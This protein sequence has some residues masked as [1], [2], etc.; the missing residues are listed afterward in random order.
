MNYLSKSFFSSLVIS[1]LLFSAV[2]IAQSNKGSIVGT[3]SDPSGAL[4]PNAKVTVT[5]KATGGTREVTSNA[6]GEFSVSNL[7]PGNYSVKVEAS[8]FKSILLSSLTVETN[9]RV[10]IAAVFTEVAGTGTNVVEV[11]ADS[12]PLVESETS[13]RGDLITG[14]EVTDLPIP[15]RNFTL[16][17]GLSPGVT[18][19]SA[20]SVGV[21]GGGGNFVNGGPGASSESTRFRESGGSVISANGARV[22]QNNF[23]LD[24]VDNNESQFGQIAVYPNPDAIAEFKIE[25]SVPSAESGRAAGAIIST[26]FKSGGNE[27][28]GTIFENYQGRFLS[29]GAAQFD[30]NGANSGNNPNYVTHNYGGTVGGPIF[31]PRPGINNKDP[32][33]YDGRNRSF[34]FVS[35]AGQRNGTP[36]FGGGEF[37]FVT[38]PTA[39][40]RAGD[41]SELLTGGNTTY[42]L[43][44]GGQVVAPTGTIFAPDGTPIPGNNL[45]NCA[46]CGA[47]SVYGSNLL[48]AYPLPTEAGFINNYRRNRAERSTVDSYDV[49]IDHRINDSNTIFGRYSRAKNSRIRDNNFPLGTSPNG[50]DLPSGFGAGDEFGNSRGITLGATQIFSPTVVNDMRAGW[51]KVQIGINNPGINGSLGFNPGVDAALGSTNINAC[52]TCEG[53]SLIGIVD[54]SFSQEFVGDGGPFFFLSNNYNFADTVTIARGNS[55]LKFG[56]DLRNRRNTNFDGGR[57]GGT[58]GQYQY[59]T[60]VGGFASGNYNGIGPNDTGSAVANFLLGYQPGFLGRGT[61]G[62]PYTLQSS[63]LAFFVQNDWK[64]SPDLT[65]NLGLRYDIFTA[66]TERFDRQVNFDPASGNLIVAGENAPGG[67]DLAKNDLNNFGPRI[68]FAY[69][70]FMDRKLVVRGGYGLVYTTDVSGVQP[71]TANPGTGAANFQ[72][73]PI[74]NPGGCPPTYPVGRYPFETGIPFAPGSE[75][76][77]APGTIFPAPGGSQIIFNDPDRRDAF[78]HQYNLTLQYEFATNWLA[79]IAYVGSQ[80]RNLLTVTNIGNNND[81]GGPGSREVANISNVIATR[82]NASANYNSMQT[83]LEK[84]FTDGLSILSTY[85][86]AKAISDNP[87]GFCFGGTGPSTCGPD[88]PLRPELDRALSDLDVR[89]RFTFANV[90]DL[91]IGIG[92][93]Y[94]KDIPTGLDYLIGGWQLNNIVTLQSGPVFTVT[95]GGARVNIVGDPTPTQQQAA[96]GRQLNINAFAPPTIPVFANDPNGPKI[97]TLGRNTFRGESQQYWDANI[98]KNFPVRWI[99]EAFNVQVRISVFNVLNHVN[100]SAPIADINDVTNF[101]RD[102]SEQR[103]RQME[104]GLKIIF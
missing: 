82:N 33:F 6:S 15:Q 13:V 47:F 53:I 42:N 64:A 36:A 34:F 73:T 69:S 99:S 90:Y 93:K 55:I 84:R 92:R 1:I 7:D 57:N 85:T 61:P 3:V 88:D 103:R 74:T 62:G 80:S 30:E 78:V 54:P 97:G 22:T 100:R 102:F 87:G 43:A 12:A 75:I 98:F 37:P 70:G 71:L 35:V 96:E 81:N 18:R 41:F 24:G 28:H 52:G 60:S 72:C 104:F 46:T 17:A 101:G 76:A 83:K 29:A 40:M 27:F 94:L 14:R 51:T 59:G 2:A 25:T 50:N 38:V 44:G 4:V 9:A 8:G 11:T 56:T 86:F 49:K 77:N 58:K 26:T 79:E 66:P 5:N 45:A 16:L 67:R 68:G 63:E 39:A 20:A 31:F 65:L 95:Q 48:N 10:P 91:P 21:L 19:P 89:H 32:F 23:S